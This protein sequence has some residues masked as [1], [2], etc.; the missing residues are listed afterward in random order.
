MKQRISILIITTIL[1]FAQF[2][3]ADEGMWIPMLLQKY[4]YADMQKKGF[5]LTPED[6]YSVNKACMKDAVVI[7]GRG[8]TGELVSEQG[9]LITNHH[10][11]YGAIQAQSSVEHD[12]L[13][14]GFWAMSKKE[15]LPALGVTVTFLIRMEDVTAKVLQNVKEADNEAIREKS[16]QTAIDAIKKEESQSN[17]Y[18]IVVKPFYYGNEYYMF[19]YEVYKDVR[20]VGAPPSAIGKFGGDTDNWMWPRHTG[21][22][23]MFRIYANKDN[24]P[25]AYSSENIPY[26]PKKYFPISLKGVQKGDFTMVFGYPGST[27]EYLPSFA[28]KM[29]LEVENPIQIA[30]REKKLSILK[31]DMDA[32]AKVRIQ[33]SSKYA[34]IANYWKKWIG[35]NKGL[36]KLNAIEK[37]QELEKQFTA[38]TISDEALNKKYGNILKKY[39]QIYTEMT[40]YKK[41]MTYIL[42]GAFA[43]EIVNYSGKFINLVNIDKTDTAKIRKTIISLQGSTKSFFKDYNLPTDKKVFIAL[44]RMYYNGLAKEYRPT[45]FAEFDKKY[46]GDFEKYADYI[47]SKS[48]FADISKV[49]KFL[50]S[51]NAEKDY[52]KIE[53]DPA[54]MLYKSFI[55]L[56]TQKIQLPYEALNDSLTS[57]DRNYMAA[58]REMLKNKTFYPDAN[59]TLR[60]AYG[61][62]DSYYP[63]DGV[64]YDYFTTLD[65]IIAKDDTS[66]Y[67]YRVPKKLKE[68]YKNKDYG[69]Y[70]INGTMPVCFSASNHTTGGNSG[71]PVVNANGE[72]IGVNFDR[73]WEGTMS[74]LMYDPDQCRNITLDIRYLLFIV[75]KFAG[76]KHLID[77]M[78][79]SN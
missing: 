75:D 42:E 73:N 54:Y 5:K 71:S 3:R 37:K 35:E 14:D 15:E 47:Y 57:L 65:G 31:T 10:C 76:A 17:Q 77:E 60:V 39:E 36:K 56:Y 48:L 68:L 2:A 21:D 61:K 19:V 34:G 6:I 12:Y 44:L 4:N 11:G 55:D 58:Q 78:S 20:L 13:T 72:L 69:N 30:L 50:I 1:I 62:V 9:L 24:K 40:P 33:Y 7:F 63:S 26:K 32:S 52:K 74:D 49:Q 16:I 66:I 22:F 29:I 70:G 59:F 27:E 67:D 51:Y 25:A 46:K 23:S 79:I 45:I 38:W 41:A 8:C 43:A 28:I 18:E 53:K 64:F